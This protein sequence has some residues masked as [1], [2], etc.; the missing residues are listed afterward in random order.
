VFILLLEKLP[1]KRSVGVTRFF[2]RFR[3]SLTGSLNSDR[4][5]VRRADDALSRQADIITGFGRNDII[6]LP[7]SWG[8]GGAGF[9]FRQP[10]FTYRQGVDDF[11]RLVERN[12]QPGF[13]GIY[14]FRTE[15][16]GSFNVLIWNRGSRFLSF[17]EDVSIGLIGYRGP[18]SI[19]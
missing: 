19:I 11:G 18:V 7:G 1:I 13:A 5:V 9:T 12:L 2:T 10:L 4:F 15:S 3:D 17:N 16:S 8:R 14:R 6:D